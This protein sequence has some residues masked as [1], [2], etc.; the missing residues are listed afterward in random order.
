METKRKNRKNTA[1]AADSGNPITELDGHYDPT[2]GTVTFAITHLSYS[3]L[4]ACLVS[5]F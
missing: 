3:A 2:T 5:Q 1:N 4:G